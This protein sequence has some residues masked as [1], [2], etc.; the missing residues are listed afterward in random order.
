MGRVIW[1]E[2]AAEERT[3]ELLFLNV[4]FVRDPLR[5]DPRFETLTKRIGLPP[6]APPV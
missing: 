2:R 5:G 4:R 6:V 3:P 1:L